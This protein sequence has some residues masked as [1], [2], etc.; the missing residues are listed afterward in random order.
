MGVILGFISSLITLYAFLFLIV[1]LLSYFPSVDRSN[2]LVQFL[3][4][5]T[6]PVLEPLRRLIPPL[7]GVIDISA[8]VAFIALR[9]LA[10]MIA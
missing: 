5:V 4:Q 6:E 7:G 3:Y 2:P 10:S 1:P 8:M 9:L